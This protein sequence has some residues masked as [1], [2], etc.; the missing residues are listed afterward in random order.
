MNARIERTPEIL[1]PVLGVSKDGT[2]LYSNEASEP[3]LNEWG[4]RIGEKL[5]SSIVDLVQRVITRDSP[6][7][8][9]VKVRKKVYVFVFSPLHDEQRVNISGFD[10]NDCI[11]AEEDLQETNENG[12]RKQSENILKERLQLAIR[13]SHVMVYDLDVRSLRVNDMQGLDDL[14]G[15]EL[16]EVEMTFEWWDRQIFSEDIEICHSAF[17]RMHT[18]PHD[19][20]I[21]YRVR[22]KDGRILWVEDHA[23]PVCD[24]FGQVVRIVGTVMDITERVKAEEALKESEK[25]FRALSETSP[26]GV[27][28]SSAESK[29]IYT[30]PSCNHILGYNHGELIGRKS[31]DVYWNPEERKSWCRTLKDKGGVRDF[32]IKFKKKDGTPIWVSINTSPISFGGRKAV[33]GAIQDISKRKQAEEA[34][35]ESELKYRTLSNTLEEKVKERTDKLEKAYNSLK[36]SEK[37]LAEAQ[38]IAHIGNWVWDIATGKEYWSDELYRIFK[39]DPKDD[40]PS[41]KEYLK[42]VH[43]DD[44]DYVANAFKGTM[45]GKSYEIDHRVIFANGEECVVHIQAEVIFND[46]NIPI[47]TKGTVQDITERKKVEEFVAKIENARK[48]EI[49]HRIK[50]NLQ[51]I[52]SLLDLQADKFKDKTSIPVSDV[53]NAFRESQDRVI[54]MALIHE[55]LHNCENTEKVEVFAYF[56]ELVDN[57]FQNYRLGN[58]DINLDLNIENDTSFDMDTAVPLGLIVNELLSNSLKY[59]FVDRDNGEIKI[60]LQR[61]ETGEFNTNGCRNINYVLS[62][63]DNG[64]GIPEDLDIKGLDSL[65]LQLVTTLV[66][67]LDGELELRRGNGTKFIIRFMATENNNSVSVPTTQ[68]SV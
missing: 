1:N 61:D 64:V 26:I 56:K 27:G 11:E 48:K 19:H 42:Y 28:V 57:L 12:E 49:H 67:Q 10:I 25:R 43:S 65:G 18:Q 3:I 54:S 38:K 15:Y 39:R 33:M 58:N 55:E 34:L 29:I 17:E 63:S 62:V 31:T 52:S 53:L 44:R 40:V 14:L 35:R 60:K 37:N 32:E 68:Q 50:N 36:E 41:Y 16:A 2:V 6:E 8:I 9:E 51:V 30:N 13:A 4:M 5:P 45:N 46:K 59:A 20:M 7:K 21:H 23:T 22:H 24:E 66:D 47:Q